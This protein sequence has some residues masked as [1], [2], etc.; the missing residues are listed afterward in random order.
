MQRLE[1]MVTY[2]L[3]PNRELIKPVSDINIGIQGEDPLSLIHE[4]VGIS[5]LLA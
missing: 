3:V 1:D 2:I 5:T 4:V